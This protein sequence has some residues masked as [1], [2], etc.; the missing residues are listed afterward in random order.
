[1]IFKDIFLMCNTLPCPNFIDLLIFLTDRFI[2]T[3]DNEKKKLFNGQRMFKHFTFG[4][5]QT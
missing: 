1:M 2:K 3:H 4:S 5:G